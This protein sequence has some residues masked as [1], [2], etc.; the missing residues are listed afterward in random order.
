MEATVEADVMVTPA[1]VS[2]GVM[3]PG[4]AKQFNVVIKGKQP[5]QIDKIECDSETGIFKVRLPQSAAIA[6]AFDF[7]DDPRSIEDKYG[8]ATSDVRAMY[9]EVASRL[10]LRLAA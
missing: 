9:E 2:L 5:F 6:D 8:D 1:I 7:R 3:K 10:T 4:E